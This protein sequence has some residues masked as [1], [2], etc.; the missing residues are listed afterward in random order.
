MCNPLTAGRPLCCEC[1]FGTG[2]PRPVACF[3][4]YMRCPHPDVGTCSFSCFKLQAQVVLARADSGCFRGQV[5]KIGR[6]IWR[7]PP[8]RNSEIHCAVGALKHA[9][10]CTT[11]NEFTV[12]GGANPRCTRR[13]AQQPFTL[14]FLDRAFSNYCSTCLRKLHNTTAKTDRQRDFS[15]SQFVMPTACFLLDHFWG[16]R[17]GGAEW[18]T[19][20][21]CRAL[22]EAG[23]DVHYI[24]ESLTGKSGQTTGKEGII[25]H[26][27]PPLQWR[28]RV[29]PAQRRFRDSVFSILDEIKPD[30]IYTRGNN[31]FTGIG[32][33][34]RY[35]ATRMT[36]VAW[37]AAADW[38]ISWA[39]YS[40]R[41]AYYQKSWWRKSLLWLD[42]CFKD[43][44]H[45]N[46]I[47]EADTVIVQTSAQQQLVRERFH[48]EAVVLSSSHEVPSNLPAK[49]TPMTVVFVAHIGRRKRVDLF[50]D[51]ARRC[52]DMD[53]RFQ[54]V[55]DFADSV[56]EKEIRTRAKEL[57]KIEFLGQQ[58][59]EETNRLIA[60]SSLLVSTTDAGR[61]GYPNVFGP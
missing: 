18:Q 55:S 16:E 17:A 32:V 56:H 58:P 22:R 28:S 29:H 23:W 52:A 59:T 25:V 54:V 31:A 45:G 43:G 26:W 49:R 20:V 41:L 13:I 8:V 48:K 33:T 2:L 4:K 44:D 57:S 15:I 27:L 36:K 50:V 14:W 61:E 42:A 39:F 40:Q 21:L 10:N 46:E 3:Q 53:A 6:H 60:E 19:F 1:I 38:E 11:T 30:I 37:G 24:A 35:R 12:Q 34:H 47:H 7:V 51:L 9:M 5:G